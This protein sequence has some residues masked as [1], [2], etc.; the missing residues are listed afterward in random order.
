M[1][2]MFMYSRVQNIFFFSLVVHVSTNFYTNETICLKNA[3]KQDMEN[4]D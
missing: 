1:L 3:F 4:V 2:D